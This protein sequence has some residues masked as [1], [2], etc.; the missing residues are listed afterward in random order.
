[1]PLNFAQIL[2]KKKKIPVSDPHLKYIL[3]ATL[4]FLI[5]P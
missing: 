3:K 4:I 2:S 1:M 5:Q